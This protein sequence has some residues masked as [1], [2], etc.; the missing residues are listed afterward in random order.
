MLH[1]P[2]PPLRVRCHSCHGTQTYVPQSDAIPGSLVSSCRRCGSSTVEVEWVT[3]P[4]SKGL[5]LLKEIY[6]KVLR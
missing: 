6:T 1:H 2:P 4:I 5:I 3:N